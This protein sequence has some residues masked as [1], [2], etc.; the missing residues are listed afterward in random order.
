VTGRVAVIGLPFFGPRVA[1]GLRR[2]GIDA[3]FVRRPTRSPH[4]WPH[5]ARGL[6]R[7]DLIYAIGSSAARN[8]PMDIL[9]RT[10]KRLVMHWVGSDVLF[11]LA[12]LRNGRL[13]RRLLRRAT[14]YVGAPWLVEE[15]AQLGV[16]PVYHPLPVQTA[17][18]SPVPFPR[19]F[20]VLVYLRRDPHQ[21]YDVGSTL[22]VID[23]LP[24]V[25]FRIV[26]GFE[27]DPPRPNVECLGF[28]SDMAGVYP[29]TVVLLRLVHHDGLSHS[30][31]EALSFGRYVVW[32]FPYH[33]GVEQVGSVE[34][35]VAAIRRLAAAF[36]AGA[37]PLNSS[38][39][40]A[41][42]E[43]YAWPTIEA[44]FQAEFAR[45]LS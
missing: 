9:S 22:A 42:T 32:S 20:S 41:V 45:L 1:D 7:A 39:A 34:E 29:E 38:A 2:F 36:S 44:E 23:A 10:P 31:I 37:L 15:L 21:V 33:P 11:G 25:P 8:S 17:I 6:A 24:D 14:H 30:V 19:R 4:T 16:D 43:R 40:R 28:V 27:P 35:A 26:G 3:S 5:T 13:S 18:G 12:D